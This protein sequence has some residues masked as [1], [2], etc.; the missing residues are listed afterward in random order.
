MGWRIS[1][2]KHWNP[3]PWLPLSDLS[4]SNNYELIQVI[5]VEQG[6]EATYGIWAMPRYS[7][8]RKDAEPWFNIFCDGPGKWEAHDSRCDYGLSEIVK[9][10]HIYNQAGDTTHFCICSC[11]WSGRLEDTFKDAWD[12]DGP[13][14]KNCVIPNPKGDGVVWNGHPDRVAYQEKVRRES[15]EAKAKG[16]PDPHEVVMVDLSPPPVRLNYADLYKRRFKALEKAA[17]S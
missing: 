4:R 8:E 1:L 16:L 3:G 10:R 17:N 7:A 14:C 2:P 12:D 13:L 9:W 6:E 5:L 11:G 15:A